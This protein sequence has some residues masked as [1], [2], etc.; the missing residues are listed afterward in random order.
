VGVPAADLWA[1]PNPRRRLDLLDLGHHSQLIYGERIT[2]LAADG[3]WLKVRA[4]E[5]VPPGRKGRW[6]GCTGWMKAADL[7]AAAPAAADAV[8]RTRQ[9]ILKTS[10]GLLTLSV[11]T[12]LQRLAEA[13]GTT[14]VRLL[15]G[16]A[17]EVAS[18]AL[19]AAATHPGPQC[20]PLI[21]QTAELF[22][23]TRYYWGGRSGVQA[24][25]SIGVDCSGLA[26][27]AY[28][29]CGLDL[30]H[31]A[32]EQRLCSRPVARRSLRPGDLV[33]LSAGADSRK[34]T[35]V[36]IYTGGDGLIEARWAAG[37][38]LRCTF[39]ERFGIPLSELES[40][41]LVMDRTFP[42]PRR[43]RIFFGSYFL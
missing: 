43:R 12:R 38:V 23:G 1:A 22:L 41:R 24:E 34:I 32:Q 40:G 7:T 17:A 31:N 10:S 26:S 13:A 5:P 3:A 21:L 2:V 18:D 33:F 25:P 37:R 36:L 39:A 11:G 6:R 8:V 28:R 15:D 14:R 9:A 42:R 19:C 35:H 30:P 4:D 29:V 27:L 16:G 20:R